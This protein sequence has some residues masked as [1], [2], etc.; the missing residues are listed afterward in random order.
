MGTTN[1]G[2]PLTEKKLNILIIISS[3]TYMQ[4]SSTDVTNCLDFFVSLQF[5]HGAGEIH[6]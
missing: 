6:I 5:F 2:M 4:P 3:I 1:P